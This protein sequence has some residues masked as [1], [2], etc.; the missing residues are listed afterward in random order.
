M[1]TPDEPAS[2]ATSVAAGGLAADIRFPTA[3]A[4]GV[5]SALAS[6]NYRSEQF[7]NE[8]LA[9][10]LGAPAG[11]VRPESAP[12]IPTAGEF[13][14]A[15]WNRLKIPESILRS[16]EAVAVPSSDAE[17]LRVVQGGKFGPVD[18]ALYMGADGTHAGYDPRRI[19]TGAVAN[20]LNDG[21]VL[22]LNYLQDNDVAIRRICEYLQTVSSAPVNANAYISRSG[23]SGTGWHWDNHD[24]ILLQLTGSKRWR[25]CEPS[26]PH[27]VVGP[28]MNPHAGDPV[29]DATISSGE[30]VYIP[31]GYWHEGESDGSLS[32]HLTIGITRPTVLTAAAMWDAALFHKEENRR[33]VRPTDAS[34]PA[35]VSM[36]TGREFVRHFFATLASTRQAVSSTLLDVSS[37]V[38]NMDS[39]SGLGL[40]GRALGAGGIAIID[41]PG[42]DVTLLFGG[43]TVQTDLVTANLLAQL[44]IGPAVDFDEIARAE[45]I[46]G[47]ELADRLRPILVN[48]LLDL[49]VGIER[50]RPLVATVPAASAAFASEPLEQ[51]PAGR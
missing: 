6:A 23:P 10:L 41:R 42:H 14:V 5:E 8:W 4:G 12:S 1:T 46:D 15:W 27:P 35:S 47:I 28:T 7:A 44:S 24:V 3:D 18:P 16:A 38:L 13:P 26:T 39:W 9:A 43:K 48:G 32:V 33:D 34:F 20:L 49:Y 29:F 51:R 19:N 37:N 31:R 30:A 45:A 17:K 40:H 50:D 11:W 25:I 2:H 22:N 21:G 36:P